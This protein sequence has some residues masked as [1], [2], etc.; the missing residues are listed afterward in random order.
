MSE[1]HHHGIKGQRWGV[2][3]FQK[4]NGSYTEAGKKRYLGKNGD[5]TSLDRNSKKLKKLGNEMY[6]RINN[7]KKYEDMHEDYRRKFLNATA[8]IGYSR[9]EQRYQTL[10]NNFRNG[11]STYLQARTRNRLFNQIAGSNA[12]DK[13]T[14]RIKMQRA[15]AQSL[16]NKQYANKKASQLLRDFGYDDNAKSREYVTK[17]LKEINDERIKKS[18]GE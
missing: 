11:R 2:R 17:L 13:E 6:D 5:I 14:R 18:L 16:V 1:L 3:R 7:N 4:E 10:T 15:Q 9:K 8:G 12:R